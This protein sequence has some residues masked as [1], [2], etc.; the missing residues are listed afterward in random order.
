MGISETG[1]DSIFSC[2]N[3]VTFSRD[4]S[5][6]NPR[7]YKESYSKRASL[8]YLGSNLRFF[9]FV[10]SIATSIF[11]QIHLRLDYPKEVSKNSTAI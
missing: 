8:T 1:T 5:F 4:P 2:V 10:P 6:P 7:S 3:F 9:W 11:V